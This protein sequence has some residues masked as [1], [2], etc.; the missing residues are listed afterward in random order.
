[1]HAMYQ[2]VCKSLRFR[3][4]IG[5]LAP[6]DYAANKPQV[7]LENPRFAETSPVF[8]DPGF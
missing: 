4:R 7:R 5:H 3:Q 8:T 2:D 6:A 1:M